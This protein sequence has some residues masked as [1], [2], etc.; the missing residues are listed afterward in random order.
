MTLKRNI[1]I[2]AC[3]AAMATAATTAPT[4]SAEVT[5]SP[6]YWERLDRYASVED[7][8]A[9]IRGVY[10]V[11]PECALMQQQGEPIGCQQ[12]MV[13]MTPDANFGGMWV[14]DPAAPNGWRPLA[15]GDCPSFYDFDHPNWWLCYGYW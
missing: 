11:P 15:D 7:T 9:P 8:W 12:L 6:Q 1:T 4:A 2:A 13:V 14:A 10:P 5:Y 3:V